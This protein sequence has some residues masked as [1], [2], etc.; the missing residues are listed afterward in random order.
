MPHLLQVIQTP[1]N[2][3]FMINNKVFL[4]STLIS[5]VYIFA[6]RI[7]IVY[8]IEITAFDWLNRPWTTCRYTLVRYYSG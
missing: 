3:W 8:F 1:D 5:Y 4:K 7:E 2:T 6:R